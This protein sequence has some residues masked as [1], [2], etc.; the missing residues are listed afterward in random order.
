[1]NAKRIT[2]ALLMDTP[3]KAACFLL[4][5]DVTERCLPD[6]PIIEAWQ[7]VQTLKRQRNDLIEIWPNR[8]TKIEDQFTE[9]VALLSNNL[10]SQIFDATP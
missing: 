2:A 4:G 9:Q 8:S 3:E 1:M 10:Y 7:Q 6:E 5:P